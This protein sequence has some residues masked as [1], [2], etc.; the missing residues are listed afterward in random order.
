MTS[1]LCDCVSHLLGY[2]DFLLLE[3][4]IFLCLS[5][6]LGKA[7]HLTLVGGRIPRDLLMVL[8][9]LLKDKRFGK[10]CICLF[11]GQ[12][13]QASNFSAAVAPMSKGRMGKDRKKNL[14]KFKFTTVQ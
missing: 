14:I 11:T 4:G 12:L 1:S 6:V 7:R 9:A 10:F 3:T 2:G 13:F 5:K 8:C